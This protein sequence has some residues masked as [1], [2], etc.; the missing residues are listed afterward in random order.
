[1]KRALTKKEYDRLVEEESKL[2]HICKCGHRV[3]ITNQQSK[4]LCDW[5]GNY[6]F[7][8]KKEEFKY[9]MKE[10]MIRGKKNKMEMEKYNN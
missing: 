1:M 7:K 10:K 6:V 8:N 2:K 3:I 9:R 4:V 5:C